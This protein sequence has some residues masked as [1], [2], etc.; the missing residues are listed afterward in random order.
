MGN[1]TDNAI[2]GWYYFLL[3]DK[4]DAD[5]SICNLIDICCYSI[6]AVINIPFYE[7]DGSI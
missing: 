3:L 4:I 2:C 7:I 5:K 6:G 1:S